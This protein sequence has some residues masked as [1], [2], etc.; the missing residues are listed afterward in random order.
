MKSLVLPESVVRYLQSC[1]YDPA[2][3][4][5]FEMIKTILSWEDEWPETGMTHEVLEVLHDLWIARK[6]IY[7]DSCGDG[8]WPYTS[9]EYTGHCRNIWRAG[10]EQAGNWPGF[11]ADRLHLN[12][13]DRA[14]YKYELAHM[15][16]F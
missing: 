4:P 5:N 12:A 1:V 10:L 2:A 8:E 3:E 14:Y 11:M 16:D 13:R 6:Y 15:D 7:H 9:P